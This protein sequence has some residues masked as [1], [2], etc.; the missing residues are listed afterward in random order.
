MK[1]FIAWVSMS[2]FL[3]ITAVV[4][5]S[6]NGIDA[7]ADIIIVKKTHCPDGFTRVPSDCSGQFDRNGNCY[8]CQGPSGATTDD[9]VPFIIKKKV[10]KK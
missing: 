5:V 9:N 7:E 2:I 10:P 8:T 6:M 1:K 3:A 4:I